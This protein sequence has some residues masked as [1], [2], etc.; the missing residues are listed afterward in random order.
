MS[1][2]EDELA[3]EKA[4]N[5]IYSSAVRRALLIW[6]ENHPIWKDKNLD[7]IVFPGMAK[8]LAWIL[9]EYENY[10]DYVDKAREAW[11]FI[12]FHANASEDTPGLSALCVEMDEALYPMFHPEKEIE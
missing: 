10:K 4:K 6:Q 2:I 12:K 5:K 11:K 8:N 7:A 1:K 3:D 9:S